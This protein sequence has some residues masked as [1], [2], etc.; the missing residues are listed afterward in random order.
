[1]D[2]KILAKMKNPTDGE[3]AH[4]TVAITYKKDDAT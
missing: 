3:R 4:P 2:W 1:M